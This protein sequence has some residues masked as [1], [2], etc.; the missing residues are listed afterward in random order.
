MVQTAF[1]PAVNR[2]SFSHAQARFS[3]DPNTAAVDP[4]ENAALLSTRTWYRAGTEMGG[5]VLP[6][7]E[8]ASEVTRQRGRGDGAHRYV[9]S[10]V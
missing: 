9:V 7:F 4:A 3:S 1:T 10:P 5:V 6:Y 8:I 2:V